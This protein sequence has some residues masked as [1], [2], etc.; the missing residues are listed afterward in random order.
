MMTTAAEVRKKYPGAY[1]DMSDAQ[2]QAAIDKKQARESGMIS[3]SDLERKMVNGIQNMLMSGDMNSA[4]AVGQGLLS[5]LKDLGRGYGQAAKMTGEFLGLTPKGG[6][7]EYTREVDS[8]RNAEAQN[9][10]ERYPEDALAYGAGRFAGGALPLMAIPGG[11]GG[12]AAKIIQSALTGGGIGASQYVPEG[13]SRLQNTIIGSLLGGGMPAAGAALTSA[14]VNAIVGAGKGL[15][16]KGIKHLFPNAKYSEKLIAKDLMNGINT[17]KALRVKKEAEE[18]GLQLTPGQASGSESV[19]AA[20]NALGRSKEGQASLEKFAQLQD[21]QGRNI[22]KK[23][24]NTVSKER[25]DVSKEARDQA[26]DIIF[27][28]KKQRNA[29]ASPMYEAAKKDTIPSE[30]IKKLHDENPI[31]Q[32]AYKDVEKNIAYKKSL[33]GVDKNTIEYV[34]AVK[35]RLY[36][37]EKKQVPGSFEAGQYKEARKEL[38]SLADANSETYPI[39]RALFSVGSNP[40]NKLEASDIK[41]IASLKDN[42]L[43]DLTKI[44][45][46]PKKENVKSMNNIRNAFVKK[47]PK[48][49]LNIVRNEMDR[50]LSHKEGG[51]ALPNFFNTILNTKAKYGQF[52]SALKGMPQAQKRLTYMKNAAENFNKVVRDKNLIAQEGATHGITNEANKAVSKSF[53]SGYDKKAVEIMTSPDWD[54]YLREIAKTSDKMEKAKK[55]MDLL[56]MPAQRATVAAATSPKEGKK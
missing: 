10:A 42:Q 34:D 15:I 9:A 41:K 39:A 30:T 36:T 27:Q 23:T 40:V 44:I 45:F 47:D 50:V 18:L 54:K 26:K 31:I 5:G 24:L 7:E 16:D 35:K 21:T 8:L 17:E 28:E 13:E 51:N 53:L 48:L 22:V 12:I 46:D 37:L 2:L 29:I 11:Q 20:E 14:P 52:M 56:K 1:D 38:V 25:K 49:W 3:D 4:L 32:A 55:F 19:I 43:Q 6:A 33:K